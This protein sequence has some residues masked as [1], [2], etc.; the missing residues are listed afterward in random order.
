MMAYAV[1][2]FG[3]P[4]PD[5]V[6]KSRLIKWLLRGPFTASLTLAM[7]TIIRRA[8]NLFG[9]NPYSALVPIVMIVTILLCEF[10]IT[11]FFPKLEQA[12][13]FGND[14]DELIQLRSLEERLITRSDLSQFLEMVLAAICDQLQA[15]GAY[16]AAMNPE[17]FEVI[18]Q[19]GE[20]KNDPELAEK[21]Q[22]F[23]NTQERFADMTVWEKDVIFPLMDGGAEPELVGY[24][25]IHAVDH[26]LLLE[27]GSNDFGSIVDPPGSDRGQRS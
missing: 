8:G 22:A 23:I 20:S 21:F 11:L 12:I 27:G 25:G 15:P 13:L 3:V 7:V 10:I 24:L 17:G 26:Q 18:V 9:G 19:T 5:R 16:L 2:F 14:Q 4:W 1:A 6:V